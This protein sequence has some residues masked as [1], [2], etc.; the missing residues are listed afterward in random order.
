MLT[1]PGGHL[2]R[3][4][5]VGSPGSDQSLQIQSTVQ[6]GFQ[7]PVPVASATSTSFDQDGTTN[8]EAS[9]QPDFG[10]HASPNFGASSPTASSL[11]DTRA[12]F[13]GFQFVL[14][15]DTFRHLRSSR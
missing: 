7:Q 6:A 9:G 10:E 1:P 4:A 13:A 14:A 3:V 11:G 5:F 2:A 12:E 8:V 15:Y